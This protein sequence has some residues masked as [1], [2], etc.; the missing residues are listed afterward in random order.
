MPFILTEAHLASLFEL[1]NFARPA[2]EMLFIGLR[3]CVPVESN[4][5][6]YADEHVF[7]YIGTDHTHLRCSFLQW[8]PGSGFAAFPGSTVPHG[9]AVS[10]SIS[11]DGAGTNQLVLGYY[12]GSHSYYKGDHKLG[13]ASSRHRAFRND[14]ILPVWRTANDAV[15]D[16]SDRLDVTSIPGDNIHCAWQQNASAPNFSSNGCQV[17][18]GRP[19]VLARGWTEELGPWA[20]FVGNA[21]DLPQRRFSYALF[22]GREAI[23]LAATT[24]PLTNRY[25]TV[26]FGSEGP[27]VEVVQDAL[28]KHGYDLGPAGADGDFGFATIVALQ[29]FQSQQFGNGGI[30]LIVGPAT[31][32]ALGLAWPRHNQG[33]PPLLDAVEK[34]AGPT[35]PAPQP[36]S[37][38]PSFSEATAPNYRSLTPGGV[39]S[40]TPFDLSI[41]RSIRTNNPGALNITAWQKAFR[42]YAGVTQS[43]QAGNRTTIYATPE[44]GIAAWYFLLDKRYGYGAAGTL[45]VGDLAR[46]YAGV[47]APDHPAAKS[48]VTGWRK[49]S[50]NI[51]TATAQLRLDN[52]QDMLTLARGMFGHEIGAKSPL[53]DNQVTNALALLR[54]DTLPPA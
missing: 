37:A 11:S 39:F 46:R 27:L 18:V 35:F 32:K 50:D 22:D 48:Y 21:Y 43:D 52:D 19:R 12:R 16:G 9:S 47:A 51:L 26:R 2:G 49:W 38:G 23:S 1:A 34:F 3:G 25:P 30:D 36:A 8:I 20:K 5:A 17:I 15:Y 41:K 13:K 7:E 33:V 31:G 4:A 10:A 44:H 6:D 53:H 40:A 54:N 45:V 24:T 42:G 29:Q 28:I 14:S